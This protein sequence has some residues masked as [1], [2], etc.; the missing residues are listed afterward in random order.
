[1]YT[2]MIQEETDNNDKGGEKMLKVKN[3]GKIDPKRHLL[4]LIDEAENANVAALLTNN[5]ATQSM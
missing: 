5:L 4:S 2:K 1:M 3:T